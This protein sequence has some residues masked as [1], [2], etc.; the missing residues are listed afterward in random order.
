MT[1][2]G[3]STHSVFVNDFLLLEDAN[4]DRV[5]VGFILRLKIFR[6][7]QDNAECAVTM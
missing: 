6:Q 2:N 5:H 1:V 4:H 3:D 7:P